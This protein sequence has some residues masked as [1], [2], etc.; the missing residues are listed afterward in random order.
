MHADKF[1][2]QKENR[3]IVFVQSQVFH[4]LRNVNL[5]QLESV[6]VRSQ[7]LDQ[8][9][10]EWTRIFGVQR[11]LGFR[12][13]RRTRMISRR[14]NSQNSDDQ[15]TIEFHFIYNNGYLQEK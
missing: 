13:L 14:E 10:A 9:V 3:N 4:I 5:L 7:F 15:L 6:P 1:I 8:I 2:V 11:Q 12:S